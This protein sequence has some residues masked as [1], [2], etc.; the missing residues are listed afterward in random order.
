MMRYEYNFA[1]L[2]EY[3]HTNGI[4]NREDITPYKAQ[5]MAHNELFP[6]GWFNQYIFYDSSDEYCNTPTD[7]SLTSENLL[8]RFLTM[9]DNHLGKRRLRNLDSSKES[10]RVILFYKIRCECENLPF[11]PS[12]KSG[13]E[14]CLI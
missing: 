4:V 12:F 14:K 3:K 9:L 13:E 7:A 2:L 6:E 11:N 8:I 1:L 5:S 10:K